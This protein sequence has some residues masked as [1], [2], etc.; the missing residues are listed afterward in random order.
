MELNKICESDIRNWMDKEALIGSNPEP[1]NETSGELSLSSIKFLKQVLPVK[2]GKQKR[3]KKQRPPQTAHSK[4]KHTN[5]NSTRSNAR[6]NKETPSAPDKKDSTVSTKPEHDSN[7]ETEC[8]T[9]DASPLD[10]N[11]NCSSCGQ[12]Y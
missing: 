4:H 8:D 5:R 9:K 6:I 11:N 7:A 2:T 3:N 10:P 1:E 12:W